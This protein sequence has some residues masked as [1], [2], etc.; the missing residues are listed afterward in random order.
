MVKKGLRLARKVIAPSPR[1]REE[2]CCDSPCFHGDSVIGFAVIQRDEVLLL[3]QPRCRRHGCMVGLA[4]GP[5]LSAL[6]SE[7]AGSP[8]G[9]RGKGCEKVRGNGSACDVRVGQFGGVLYFFSFFL[10]FL[11]CFFSFLCFIIHYFKFKFRQR[12][13]KFKYAQTK[14]KM[15]QTLYFFITLS[16]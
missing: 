6:L 7:A 11:L 14:S 8:L 9:W 12:G 5:R 10:L 15:M 13:D 3:M 2:V 1:V 16:L 4:D